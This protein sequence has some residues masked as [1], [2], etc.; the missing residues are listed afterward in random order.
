MR[1]IDLPMPSLLFIDRVV[2]MVEDGPDVAVRIG[3]LAD[4]GLTAV[5]VGSVRRVVC[6]APGYLDRHGTPTAP[7]ELRDHAVIGSTSLA[8]S[9]EWQFGGKP[10]TSVTVRPRLICSTID[11]ALAAAIDGQGVARLLSYQ[12]AP[13]VAEG[14]LR[15]VLADHEPEP[16]PVHVVSLDGRRAPAKVRAFI[17]LAVRRLR[18]NPMIN[19]ML[20][21][22]P[23]AAR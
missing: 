19:S 7:R 22:T 14:R 8:A 6:T 21:A 11:V 3:P 12:V 13:A 1:D 16:T 18:A 23:P 10:E 5:R 9:P 4:S 20:N 15:I 2:N 17:D